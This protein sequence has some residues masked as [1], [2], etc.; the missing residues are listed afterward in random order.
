MFEK[1]EEKLQEYKKS[2]PG[3]TVNHQLYEGDET[4]LIIAIVILLMIRVHK[5][6]PECGELFFTDSTSNTKERILS[7][8][9]GVI[10]LHKSYPRVIA[11][12]KVLLALV[13]LQ[14]PAYFVWYD[15]GSLNISLGNNPVFLGGNFV[16]VEPLEL[17]SLFGFRCY[18]RISR[19][20]HLRSCHV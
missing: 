18:T 4:P 17:L 10:G 14:G 19:V 6:V 20:L 12:S 11:A 15:R 5:E 3:A 9:N 13:Y 2:H 8:N 1:L 16:R 7:G